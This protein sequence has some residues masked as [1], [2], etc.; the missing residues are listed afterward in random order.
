[1]S[2]TLK[3]NGFKQFE[4]RLQKIERRTTTKLVKKALGSAA[5]VVRKQARANALEVDDPDTGRKIAQNVGQRVRSR[6]NRQ[7]GDV[8]ISIGVL[9]EPGPIPKGN[10]DTGPRGNTPHW[11]LV[12]MGTGHARAQPFLRNALAQKGDEAVAKFQRELAA[13][14]TKEPV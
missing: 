6:Y 10:P 12:E 7:T 3:L 8:K 4:D 14:I 2:V 11:H 13:M 5:A 1:M 9:S